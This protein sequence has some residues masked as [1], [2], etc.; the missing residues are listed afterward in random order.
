MVQSKI[1]LKYKQINHFF[2]D[3]YE[4]KKFAEFKN[5]TNDYFQ[6][7]QIHSNRIITI[8]NKLSADIKADGMITQEKCSL[9]IKTADCLPVLLFENKKMIIGAV[10]AGWKG[11]HLGILNEAVAE[12]CKMGGQTK[13]IIAVIGPHIG[14][15]CYSVSDKFLKNFSDKYLANK[16]VL[17]K[18]KKPFLDLGII[19]VTNII[20]LG[21]P[22]KNIEIMDV[23]TC[24]NKDYFSYRR[25][26]K[27]TGRMYNIITLS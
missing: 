20:N 24:C 21:V 3:K 12:I 25:D 17:H 6:L 22:K 18:N 13:N 5:D 2:L 26:K 1:L 23:C 15:C 7:Q 10:H 8:K 14:Q 27:E 16:T 19:A 9:L 4:S 11:L